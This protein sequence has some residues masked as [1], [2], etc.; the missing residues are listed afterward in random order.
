MSGIRGSELSIFIWN[1]G[2]KACLG[3]LC[4]KFSAQGGTY[5]SANLAQLTCAGS[6]DFAAYA[7]KGGEIYRGQEKKRSD[8]SLESGLV[9]LKIIKRATKTRGLRA[10]RSGSIA[11]R[12]QRSTRRDVKGYKSSPSLDQRCL[13]RRSPALMV[14]MSNREQ[15]PKGGPEKQP[16]GSNATKDAGHGAGALH[17]LQGRGLLNICSSIVRKK[18]RDYKDQATPRG[19]RSSYHR[20]PGGRLMPQRTDHPPLLLPEWQAKRQNL[21]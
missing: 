6:R 2:M 8:A 7:N 21:T 15:G 10:I 14:L 16:W 3:L 13:R 4:R 19:P 18:N 20:G 9:I 5:V 11:G 12:L 17:F 1:D